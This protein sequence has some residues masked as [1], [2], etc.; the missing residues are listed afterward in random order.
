MKKTLVIGSTV[1]DVII[2]LPHLPKSGEDININAPL[3][4][5]GGCAYNVYETLR[6]MESPAILCSPV[7]SGNY[8]AM[9]RGYMEERGIEPFVNLEE[10]NGCCYCLVESN[11]ER[12]FLSHHGA[13]YLFSRSWMTGLDF[14]QIDSVYV[15]GID[16][17]DRTGDEIVAFVYE[18]PELVLYFAPGPRIM[19]IDRERVNR[20]LKR[21]DN[22]GKGPILHLNKE[23]ACSFSGKISVEEAAL[24]LAGITANV[25][26]ITLGEKGCYC[27]DHAASPQGRFIAGFPAE[28]VDTTGAGDAHCGAIIAGLKQGKALAEAC[29]IANKTGAAVA[30]I[31]GAVPAKVHT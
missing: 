11:G 24:F 30:G 13:E 10:E 26:I 5:L 28:V 20:L 16:V 6:F 29:E 9:V 4:R 8:G 1:I 3:H 19:H 22:N 31:H 12:S 15:S 23:E 17:E 18:H 25:L 21:R 27:Y 14:S 7:G 2:P